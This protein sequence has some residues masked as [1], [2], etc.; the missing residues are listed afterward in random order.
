MEAFTYN[1]ACVDCHVLPDCLMQQL[2]LLHEKSLN[3]SI[4]VDDLIRLSQTMKELI[5][6]I[7]EK[8]YRPWREAAGFE[9]YR[10]LL[11]QDSAPEKPTKKS[12][13]IF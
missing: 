2:R 3:P 13:G 8:F 4:S 6:S 7:D 11:C 9:E 12:F 1:S 5:A 10:K